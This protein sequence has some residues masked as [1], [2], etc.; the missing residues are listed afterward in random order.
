MPGGFQGVSTWR[1]RGVNREPA[2]DGRAN[3]RG[4]HGVATRG[5]G[6][7]VVGG[8]PGNPGNAVSGRIRRAGWFSFITVGCI[9]PDPLWVL[10]IPLFPRFPVGGAGPP[11]TP[12][13]R[14]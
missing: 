6:D 7:G 8:N 2:G 9:N 12:V 14:T 4:I 11:S 5:M 10:V 1:P 3:W 13:K